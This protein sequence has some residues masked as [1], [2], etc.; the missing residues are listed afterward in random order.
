MTW[1]SWGFD[2]ARL[3]TIS[4]TLTETGGGDATGAISLTGQYVHH[5]GDG[6]YEMTDPQTGETDTG[7][8]GYA[9]FASALATALNA[10]GNATYTVAFDP[11]GPGYTI[12]AS[13]GSV[14]AFSLTSISWPMR[15]VLGITEASLSGALSY[16]CTDHAPGVTWP[17][18]HWTT[19]A[20]GLSQW[21]E[22][23]QQ[24]EGEDLIGSDGSVRGLTSL[25]T[26]RRL[27][28]VAAWEPGER[29][30][31]ESA[32]ANDWTWA[33]A[34]ARARTAEPL[35]IYPDP[36][37]QTGEST[38]VVCVL[39]HDGCV[40][41]PQLASA[42]Y[43]GHQGVPLGAWVLGRASLDAPVVLT[44]DA[45]VVLLEDDS[46]MLME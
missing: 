16:D 1:I 34:F 29:V 11:S 21:T 25:G 2:A 43:L 5:V 32:S 38:A 3:G 20:V 33:R 36:R 23:E 37:A 31:S 27:D 40:L 17:L 7:D 41:A 13:G 42:D 28:A 39:R 30:W 22:V 10:V 35:W 4:C 18:W 8:T 46:S 44:E 19:L 12:S 9:N 45:F 15:R 14:T 24:I 26:P 6:S